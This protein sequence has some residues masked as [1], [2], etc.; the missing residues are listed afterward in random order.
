MSE[1]I[2]VGSYAYRH[3]AE[4]ARET[5]RAAGID[6]MLLADDAGGAYTGLTFSWRARLLVRPEDAERA[7]QLLAGELPPDDEPAA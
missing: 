2:V 1:P 4:F 7:Q 5:L 6:S 3:E